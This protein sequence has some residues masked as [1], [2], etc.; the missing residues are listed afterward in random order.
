MYIYFVGK[1]YAFC[2]HILKDDPQLL[3]GVGSWDSPLNGRVIETTMAVSCV[4]MIKSN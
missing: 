2:C 3:R 1:I 4:E